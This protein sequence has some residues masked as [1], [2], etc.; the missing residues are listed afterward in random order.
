MFKQVGKEELMK[1]IK[2]FAVI[3]FTSF[4]LAGTASAVSMP[5]LFRTAI[6]DGKSEGV[7]DDNIAYMFKRSTE[8]NEPVTVRITKIESYESPS[9]GRLHVE[10]I[11][12]GVKDK[13]GNANTVN[14]AFEIS[15]CSDGRPPK[16]T[17][18]L[19]ASR[20]VEKMKSCIGSIK[21]VAE[22]SDGVV[23]GA[24][25]AN[26]CPTNGKS[27]WRYSGDCDA[28]KMKKTEAMFFPIGN[29][30]KLSIE[31]AVPTQ[32]KARKNVWDGVIVDTMIGPIGEIHLEM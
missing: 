8:S 27:Y 32:C 17:S 15:I 10:M 24:I 29:D 7:I 22:G 2:E 13:K 21:K 25:V 31:L 18:A 30:G 26:G 1:L 16:E 28:M 4:F 14:P 9:C 11:Q 5:D 23:R 20:G 12:A 19:N 6:K 3:V